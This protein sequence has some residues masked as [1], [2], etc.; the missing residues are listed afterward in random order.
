MVRSFAEELFSTQIDPARR[1]SYA[2]HKQHNCILDSGD[3]RCIAVWYGDQSSWTTKFE[4]HV[5]HRLNGIRRAF[6]EHK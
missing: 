2:K 6:M 4:R 3:L 5:N 1:Y